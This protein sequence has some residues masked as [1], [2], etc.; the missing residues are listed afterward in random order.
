MN[1]LELS[2]LVQ[3]LDQLNI[4]F[5]GAEF[6]LEGLDGAYVSN[7]TLTFLLDIIK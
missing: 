7:E 3:K 4:T 5:M 2:P 1:P 6:L